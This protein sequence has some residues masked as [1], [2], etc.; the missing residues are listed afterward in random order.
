MWNDIILNCASMSNCECQYS[1][2]CRIQGINS[3]IC[4]YYRQR[5]TWGGY[6]NFFSYT[7]D[8]GRINVIT[9]KGENE[10]IFIVKRKLIDGSGGR[11]GVG[12]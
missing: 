9:I 7:N 2:I 5:D 4:Y 1:A 6:D 11:G 12:G 8:Y 10:I 3:Y